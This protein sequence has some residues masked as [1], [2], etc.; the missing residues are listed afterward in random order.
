MLIRLAL[1]TGGQHAI[2]DED[3]L[4]VMDAKTRAE[5]RAYLVRIYG[6]EAPVEEAIAKVAD[7]EP[8]LVQERQKIGRLHAD[9]VALGLTPEVIGW[10]P[11]FPA[12]SINVRSPAQAIG[13]LYVLERATMLAGLVR[14]H[15]TRTLGDATATAYLSADGGLPGTRF[16]ALGEA[17]CRHAR[18]AS[19]KAIIS[20]AN[21]AF[22]AQRQWYLSFPS[23]FA[24]G[25][26][27]GGRPIP[28]RV[29]AKPATIIE[30]RPA[31]TDESWPLDTEPERQR[32]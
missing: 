11:A 28:L 22:R 14:R 24:T 23:T 5:Y 21:E 25:S 15:I 20:A 31:T 10:L 29:L 4:K 1:E 9:L 26:E 6:F 30:R 2:A 13:W 12:A 32:A 3:R 8:E 19:P 17:L 27:P 7:L 18:R 16:R